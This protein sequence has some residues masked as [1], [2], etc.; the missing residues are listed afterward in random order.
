MILLLGLMIFI[1]QPISSS[2]CSTRYIYVHSTESSKMKKKPRSLE[3][4]FIQAI[5][6]MRQIEVYFSSLPNSNVDIL[7]SNDITGKNIYETNIESVSSIIINL[8]CLE[9][10]QYTMRFILADDVFIGSFK[11]E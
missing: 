9:S 3:R 4:P 6:N 2:L 10:G 5:L 8:D 7:I 11:L 1:T